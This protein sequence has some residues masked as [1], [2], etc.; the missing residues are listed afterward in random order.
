[1]Q[2]C[3]AFYICALKVKGTFAIVLTTA[4]AKDFFESMTMNQKFIC[5]NFYPLRVIK[6]NSLLR[7]SC[8]N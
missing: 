5:M 7:R 8:K 3:A 6:R 2:S 1:M 4:N